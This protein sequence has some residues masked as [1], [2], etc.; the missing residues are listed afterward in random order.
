MVWSRSLLLKCS[1][2][3]VEEVGPQVPRAQQSTAAAVGVRGAC[4][5]AFSG[6]QGGA[7]CRHFEV[8]ILVG[9]GQEALNR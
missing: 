8:G 7:V 2:L 4:A 3:P 1:T 5:A 6:S 9:R